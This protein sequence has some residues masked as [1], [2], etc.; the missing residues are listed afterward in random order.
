MGETINTFSGGLSKDYNKILQPKDTYIDANNIRLTTF[1]GSN[2]VSLTNVLG[3]TQVT[4]IPNTSPVL[5][6][7]F[8]AT[9]LTTPV[10]YTINIDGMILNGSMIVTM[11]NI[12]EV[13]NTQSTYAGYQAY[14]SADN[15]YLYLIDTNGGAINSFTFIYGVS[16]TNA[17]TYI[18]A[19]T[20]LITIGSTSIRDEFFLITTNE[21]SQVPSSTGGVGQIWKLTYDK[22]TLLVN[23]TL[24]YNNYLNLTT[25]HSIPPTAIQGRYENANTKRIYWTDNFNQLRSFNAA[26]DSNF[27]N[28]PSLLSTQI[29]IDC[30]IPILKLIGGGGKLTSGMYQA[31]YRL[32]NSKSVTPFSEL[33]NLVQICAPTVLESAAT[34]GANSRSYLGGVPGTDCKKSI[35]WSIKNLDTDFDRIEIVVFNFDT[36]NGSPAIT[37]THDEP[38]PENGEFTFTYTGNEEIA[39]MTTAEF[40][41]QSFSFTHCKTLTTKDNQLIVANI[42]NTKIDFEYDA[43]AY[44]F[45]ISNVNTT[46]NDSQGNPLT[47]SSAALAAVPETHDAINPAPNTNIYKANSTTLGGTG[48]NINY[49]FGTYSVKADDTIELLASQNSDYAH[50][51]PSY[52]TGT[53]N[54]G[55]T[56]QDYAM[57]SINDGVKYA[58]LAGVMKGYQ[59]CETYRFAIV[60]YDKLGKPLFARWIGD[61]KMPEYSQTNNNPDAIATAATISNFRTSFVYN[62]ACYVQ[63]LYVKF[64][65]TVPAAIRPYTGGYRIV[66]VQ[67]EQQDKTIL[68]C[69]IL[70]QM[71]SDG[72]QLWEPSQTCSVQP[73]PDLNITGETRAVSGEASQFNFTFDSPD[74][75]L[76]SFPGYATGDKISVTGLIAKP[77]AQ[78]VVDVLPTT[79][80]GGDPYRIVKYY[81]VLTSYATAS[82]TTNSFTIE[83]S[84]MLGYG[85]NSF[86][87]SGVSAGWVYHNYTRTSPTTSTAVGSNT[88]VLGLSQALSY[89][90]TYS[91][92]E[93]TYRRLYAQYYRPVT[94]QY[95]GNTY[96]ARSR[97]NYMACGSFQPLT[98]SNITQTAFTQNVLGGDIF[99]DVYDQQRILKN[100]GTLYT[101]RADGGTKE[102]FGHFWA[103]ESTINMNLRDGIH[104]NRDLGIERGAS[105]YGTGASIYENPGYNSVYSQENTF[106]TY[107]P[108]PIN[109]TAIEEFDTR[110]WVSE[111]KENGEDNDSWG[112][113][114]PAKYYDA[115]GNYGPINAIISFRDKVY[116]FQSEGCG[117]VPI[118][119]RVLMQTT[120][121]EQLNVGIPAEVIS[122][123]EYISKTIGTKHQWSVNASKNAI[124]FFDI[125]NMTPY[126]LDG[127]SLKE[128]DGLYSYF[129]QNFNGKII[130]TDNALYN[131]PTYLRNGILTVADNQSDDV[132]FTYHNGRLN[133]STGLYEQFSKTV[134][135]NETLG[136]H[137]SSMDFAPYIYISSREALISPNPSNQRQ[138]FF[139]NEGSY[140]Q[141]YNTIFPSTVSFII[142]DKPKDTKSFTNFEWE[143]EVLNVN[144]FPDPPIDI[145]NETWNSIRV[146]N[147]Y[148][149]T[150]TL[151]LSRSSSTY[152][153]ALIRRAERSWRYSIPR[154]VL[155]LTGT[156]FDI[157]NSANFDQPRLFKDFIRDKWAIADFTYDNSGGREFICPFITTRYIASPR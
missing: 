83:E 112:V 95:G 76:G 142:N 45:P 47:V 40:L 41:N 134:S 140:G 50:T 16:T 44:R 154:N 54:F 65:V 100:A 74:F 78:T 43:R 98:D 64:N 61:I 101:G 8:N 51:N 81:D 10:N 66:R 85:N 157:L 138:L 46:V 88:L 150:G 121:A 147:S 107:I 141:F 35:T 48:V 94:S 92:F 113:F 6:L 117:V 15:T 19:Q 149:N 116:F 111:Q 120:N 80:A 11:E 23:Y 122:R 37:L 103:C 128:I 27:A 126:R 119:D 155:K 28:D 87:F 34:G 105:G 21:T 49:E 153:N 151:T 124:Y 115:E 33:S 77:A 30:T 36:L 129:E 72:A 26:D 135:F 32:K 13:I 24:L 31:S 93:G 146:Y 89:A 55:V 3:N 56:D 68:G 125:K 145:L 12:A 86:T 67:R 17:T 96:S 70:T 110:V 63:N 114:L 79:E 62:S 2:N 109:F 144:N 130:E 139:H 60:F 52:T 7:I 132:Y 9:P 1:E 91:S 75:F 131:D 59:R 127:A 106:I 104:I 82:G 143:T 137:V 5:K 18:P 58:Y 99:L 156:D 39:V 152:P 20:N 53:W 42:R 4:S 38:V 25:Y 57:N 14:A 102:G 97:N 22:L 69:G 29:P 90:T 118:S 123:P 73:T 84:A 136:K 148:Q 133:A 71:V 108:K